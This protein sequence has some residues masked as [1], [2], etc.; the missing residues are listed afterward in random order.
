MAVAWGGI[1]IVVGGAG[2]VT[3]SIPSGYSDGDIMFLACETANETISTPSGWTLLTGTPVSVS[4]SGNETRLTIF[5]QAC[6]GTVSSP[7]LADAGD[8]IAVI[9]F[10]I[11]GTDPAGFVDTYDTG[12]VTTATTAVSFPTVTTTVDATLIVNIL[13]KDLGTTNAFSSAANASL[14]NVTE[15][16]DTGTSFGNDGGLLIISG[17]KAT[18]GAVSATTD[19]SSTSITQ[20]KITLAFKAATASGT[21]YEVAISDGM[22]FYDGA[23]VK[24][25]Q[26]FLTDPLFMFDAVERLNEKTIAE[27][28]FTDDLSMSI[29]ER[30]AHL[31]EG[32]LMLDARS[33]DMSLIR[34]DSMLL[35]DSYMSKSLEKILADNLLLADNV[36]ALKEFI[37]YVVDSIMLGDSSTRISQLDRYFLEGLLVADSLS[38]MLDSFLTDK[39]FLSDSSIVERIRAGLEIIMTDTLFMLD[40]RFSDRSSTLDESLLLQDHSIKDLIRSMTDYLI[41]TDSVMRTAEMSLIEHIMLNDILSRAQEMVMYEGLMLYDVATLQRLILGTQF[42]VYA[43]L[44][45]NNLLGIALDSQ[46]FIGSRIESSDLIGRAIS[47]NKWRLQ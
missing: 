7:S 9:S 23:P 26:S 4:T 15:R 21:I 47:Y 27:S 8:H 36:L 46:D 37:A 6:S 2:N 40:S 11:T 42:L 35:D 31:V 38:K 25:Q 41:S 20:A 17:D 18:A 10:F 32:L 16:R 39:L 12:T 3:P 43:R 29:V 34:N 28:L 30:T 19:T 24:E 44:S 45:S 5:W 22:Q 13:A 1:G 33:T 14:T